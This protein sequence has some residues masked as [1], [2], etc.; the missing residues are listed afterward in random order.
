MTLRQRDLLFKIHEAVMKQSTPPPT[1]F[2][3]QT[4]EVEKPGEYSPNTYPMPLPPNV[5]PQG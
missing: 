2:A 5:K 1:T 4:G 3:P